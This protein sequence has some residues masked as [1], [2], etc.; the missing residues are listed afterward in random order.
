MRVD[1]LMNNENHVS[2]I[3]RPR[4]RVEVL[5]NRKRQ[6]EQELWARLKIWALVIVVLI[7]VSLISEISN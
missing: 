1:W 3:H 6:S 5:E 2:E 7:I 4:E